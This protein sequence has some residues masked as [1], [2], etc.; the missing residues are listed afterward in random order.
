M[1]Q[2]F[3][4]GIF[5]RQFHVQHIFTIFQ[6]QQCQ[7]LI[8]L[9]HTKHKASKGS[10]YLF[11][12][13]FCGLWLSVYCSLFFICHIKLNLNEKNSFMSNIHSFFSVLGSRFVAGIAYVKTVN[14]A[15]CTMHTHTH[16]YII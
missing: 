5:V 6:S 1:G 3:I 14:R 4:I 10:K 2:H 8:N 15:P 12:W 13:S 9:K 16:I 7:V 11:I